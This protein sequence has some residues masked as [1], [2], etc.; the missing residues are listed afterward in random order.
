[1]VDR[2]MEF[3]AAGADEF[4]VRDRASVPLES[5]ADLIELI[6]RDVLPALDG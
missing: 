1:M 5:A 2:L 3:R 4:I 6:T